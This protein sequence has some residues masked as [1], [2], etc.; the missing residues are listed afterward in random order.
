LLDDEAATKFKT[1]LNL[2]LFVI[3]LKSDG[4][5]ADTTFDKSDEFDVK[6][7]VMPP[8]ISCLP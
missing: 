8:L 4:L 7:F 3:L 1:P 6:T 2:L 5:S